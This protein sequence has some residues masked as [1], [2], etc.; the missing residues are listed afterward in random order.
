MKLTIEYRSNVIEIYRNAYLDFVWKRFVQ[1]TLNEEKPT[2]K[3]IFIP[4]DIIKTI[5]EEEDE[6]W[7]TLFF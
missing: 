4:F 7:I 3:H 1:I 2:Q 5:T 6:K